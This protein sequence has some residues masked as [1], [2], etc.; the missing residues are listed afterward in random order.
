[1]MSPKFL[2]VGLWSLIG[3]EI[4]LV[5]AY[6]ITISQGQ[7]VPNWL[8]WNGL[9]SLPSLLQA[10]HLF[11]IGSL[12]LVLL[13]FRPRM[14]RPVSWLLPL[15]LTAL[16]FYGAVDE[17]TKIHLLLKNY[18]WKAI[19]LAIL[20]A[21]P[22]ICRRDL[23]WIW[24]AHRSLALWVF[25]G[26]GIFLLGGFG[27]ESIKQSLNQGVSSDAAFTWLG[28]DINVRVLVEHIRT[29]VEE[30]AELLGETFMY[31]L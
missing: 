6:F 2:R 8:D 5:V 3:L 20:I 24:Q 22:L 19:Y 13:C 16:C 25:M 7:P 9:R 17:L 1:M 29:T 26:L 28:Q 14:Q 27:A 21:I 4:S 30:F 11:A 31:L 10:V 15:A 23:V 18:D 12:F